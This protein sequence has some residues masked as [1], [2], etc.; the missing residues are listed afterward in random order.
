[1]KL[2]GRIYN[3]SE[4]EDLKK[5]IEEIIDIKIIQCNKYDRNAAIFLPLGDLSSYGIT[6]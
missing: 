3:E 5:M 1:M 6:T 4:I 2:R